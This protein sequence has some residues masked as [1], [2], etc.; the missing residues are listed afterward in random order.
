[1]GQKAAV[2]TGAGH[3]IGRG[4]A[5]ALLAAGYGLVIGEKDPARVKAAQ[6][7]FLGQRVSVLKTDVSREPDVRR[8]AAAAKSEFGGADVLVCNAA[9]SD[10]KN[11]PVTRLTLA[12]WN[13]RLAVNLTSVFLCTKHLAPLLKK[14]S[15]SIINISSTR[16][17]MSEANSEAYAA[18]KGGMEALT[19]ALAI[20]L[21]PEVRVN[22]IR[23]G[24]I[25]TVGE[26]LSKKANEQH[27]VGRVGV[28]SDIASLVVYLASDAAKFI[29]GQAFTV[30]GG[31]TRKMVYED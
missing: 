1:M 4:I 20:S 30:D 18:S 9:I 27:P 7:W 16:S 22:A 13:L 8:L 10:P 21:G 29:T 15:G 14:R 17:L 5:E 12:D 28:V 23:P 25:D 2:I 11:A 31:M 6:K 24:W 3:G 19:H 26:K